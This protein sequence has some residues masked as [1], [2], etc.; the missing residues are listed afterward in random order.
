MQN[1]DQIL[2][3]TDVSKTANSIAFAVIINNSVHK[4]RLPALNSIFT[5]KVLAIRKAIQLTNEMPSH[6]FNILT[7]S[8]STLTIIQNIKKKNN[9]IT[10]E[11]TNLLNT[12]HKHI[13]LTWISSHNGI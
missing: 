6:S 11:I 5:A 10:N 2:E 1:N 8:L 3:F 13:T 7:D 9:E 4:F 12:T